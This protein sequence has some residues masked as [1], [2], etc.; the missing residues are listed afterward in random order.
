M[1]G[2]GSSS[3]TSTSTAFAFGFAFAFAFAVFPLLFQLLR[4]DR[5]AVAVPEGKR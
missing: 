1:L 3:S 5:S 2:D 4:L